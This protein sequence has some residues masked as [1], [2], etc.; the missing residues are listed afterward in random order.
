LHDAA[1]I[2]V[3]WQVCLRDIWRE[4][5]LFLGDD[6][7][8]ILDFAALRVDTVAGD[9]A[10]LIGSFVGADRL[11]W[12]QALAAYRQ[13]RP[14]TED[15]ARLVTVFDRSAVLLTGISWLDCVF[16]QRREFPNRRAVVERFDNALTRLES[17][18]A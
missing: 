11:A 12:E 2:A 9:L 18:P 1:G 8:A 15:E 4:N 14:L 5:V 7:T 6:V 13:L 3:P 17:L 16:H 10:R